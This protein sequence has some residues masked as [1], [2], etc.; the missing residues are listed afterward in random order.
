[1]HIWASRAFKDIKNINESNFP[2]ELV[3]EVLDL[4]KFEI[5]KFSLE[6]KSLNNDYS[7]YFNK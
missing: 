7:R 4:Y 2:L 5:L 1:M 6:L 3:E